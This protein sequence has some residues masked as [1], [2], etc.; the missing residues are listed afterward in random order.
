MCIRSAQHGATL[1]EML[2]GIAILATIMAL[3]LPSYTAWIQNTQIRA[4]TDS[5]LNGMQLARNEAV[6]QNTSV[7]LKLTTQSSWEIRLGSDAGNLIQSRDYNT[8]SKNVTVAVLPANATTIT[9]SSLGRVAAN[10]DASASITQLD[11]D[12]PTSILAASASRN[13][14]ITITASSVRMCDPT[15]TDSTDVRYC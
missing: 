4:A 11:F 3:G 10:A 13:L 9:F 6:R 15:V 5:V 2:I 14:R 7:Q 1:I 8:G 12:V